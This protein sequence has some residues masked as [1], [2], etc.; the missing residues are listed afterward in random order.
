[1][2][3]GGGGFLVHGGGDDVVGSNRGH[4]SCLWLGKDKEIVQ[5]SDGHGVFLWMPDGMQD[6]FGGVQIVSIYQGVG[7]RIDGQLSFGQQ[8]FLLF[9]P[10]KR[11]R[12]HLGTWRRSTSHGAGAWYPIRIIHGIDFVQKDGLVG[13]QRH[14]TFPQTAVFRYGGR[15]KVV[16]MQKVVV[17]AGHDLRRGAIEGALEL[18]KDGILLIQGR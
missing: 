2:W 5:G 4:L 12:L 3:W 17:R 6:F 18:V 16:D 14:M 13:Q 7:R 11:R 9:L 10:G 15:L 8:V 1:M